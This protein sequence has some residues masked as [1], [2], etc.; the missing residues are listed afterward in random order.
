MRHLYAKVAP[1]AAVILAI[2]SFALLFTLQRR[3]Y[4]RWRGAGI[5]VCRRLES[6][7]APL[8]CP[9]V[10]NP[11][12]PRRISDVKEVRMAHHRYEHVCVQHTDIG[13]GHHG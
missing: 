8:T 13:K 11:C 9:P 12:H 7:E 3:P 4:A 6:A 10:R 5:T 1:I 2:P